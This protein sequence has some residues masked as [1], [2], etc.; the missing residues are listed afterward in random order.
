MLSLWSVESL[1]RHL[2]NIDEGSFLVPVLCN[3][4]PLRDLV[5]MCVCSPVCFRLQEKGTVMRRRLMAAAHITL[6]F[7]FFFISLFLQKHTYLCF[8]VACSKAPQS[9]QVAQFKEPNDSF[10][11]C[12][13]N[14]WDSDDGNYTRD[15]YKLFRKLHFTSSSISISLWTFQNQSDA[16][17]IPRFCWTDG[18]HIQPC[19]FSDGL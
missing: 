9:S 10:G 11:Y 12:Y 15:K 3:I 1:R 4:F 16:S 17:T 7:L 8:N 19:V 2:F 13:I 18:C 5:Q 14:R 6:F